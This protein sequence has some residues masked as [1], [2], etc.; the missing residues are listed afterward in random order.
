MKLHDI[1]RQ[2]IRNLFRHRGRT[3]LTVL[4]V[5]VGCCSVVIMISIGIG[6]KISTEA[7][8]EQMGDLTM[9]T[10]TAM[11]SY[12]SAEER[13][14]DGKAVKAISSISHVSA[15][16]PKIYYYGSVTLYAGK[17]QR[18]RADYVSIVGTD[19]SKA[20]EEGYELTEGEW[21]SLNNGEVLAG[22]YLA[23]A[24]ADTRR[25]EGLNRVD[26]YNYYDWMTDSYQN[27][28]D[29]YVDLMAEPLTLVLGDS[30]D[31]SAA[32]Q[33]AAELNVGAVLRE[34]YNRGYA[35]S[36]GLFISADT[37][38][39]LLEEY[40]KQNGE[41]DPQINYSEI[42]VRADDISHVKDVEKE[43][44][45]LGFRTSSMESIREPME[46]DMRQKQMLLGCVGAVSLFVAALGIAN[47]MIMAITER[48]REIG[49]MKALGCFLR[50]IRKMF[51]L[52][53]GCIGLIGGVIGIGLSYLIS[54]LMNMAGGG[55]LFGN[56]YDYLI[57]ASAMDLSVIPWWLA[58][59][60]ILFSILVGV[61]AGLYPAEKAVR[62]SALDAMKHE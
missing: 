11:D 23:Y 40:A 5:I 19:L 30:Y 20:R 52:E 26:R 35:T 46:K 7:T 29:P 3:M 31:D 39:S 6:M 60:A 49:M 2:G 56:D 22:Q 25:P 57:D 17:G 58:V 51:L 28:P 12:D 54:W 8:L 59:F 14:L 36:E 47:T 13:M 21:N 1:A 50:D 4:G 27:L 24:F 48:F 43:I 61:G 18:Y 16:I 37:L 9:I 10:V 44:R 32:K 62:I 38:K 41:K 15:V 42:Q 34:D 53:A 55:A 45:K 33:T